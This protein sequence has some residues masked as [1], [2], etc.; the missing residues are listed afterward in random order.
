MA[1]LNDQDK[2]DI[3]KA[4]RTGTTVSELCEIY[5]VTDGT[6]YSALDALRVPRQQPHKR[7]FTHTTKP[8][9]GH[10]VQ[11]TKP[12][13]PVREWFTLAECVQITDESAEN[14][15]WLVRTRRVAGEATKDGST[16]V[17]HLP[18]LVAT[19]KHANVD[20]TQ[21]MSLLERAY[22][23]LNAIATHTSVSSTEC[24]FLAAEIKRLLKG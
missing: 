21:V 2:R 3:A 6:I 5:S 20:V 10:V 18:S 17:V 22:V 4:Y 13:I 11:P 7:P 23:Q 9:N 24:Q 14:I 19:L 15:E 16:M 12:S 1:K 8:S